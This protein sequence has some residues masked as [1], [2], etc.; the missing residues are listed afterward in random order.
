MDRHIS[1]NI[2][3]TVPPPVHLMRG[4]RTIAVVTALALT[5]LAAAVMADFTGGW[6]VVVQG[7]EGPMQSTL[8]LTQK[9]DSVA[10]SFESQV[11]SGGVTGTAR[12]DSLFITLA[13]NAN[14]QGINVTGVGALKD[15]TLNGVF[16]A[17]GMGEFPFTAKRKAAGSP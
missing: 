13:I 7:P 17:E 9:A 10:G 14:G 8:T 3:I 1:T 4:F 16:L 2:L 12:G 6:D 11:G 5:S 15:G